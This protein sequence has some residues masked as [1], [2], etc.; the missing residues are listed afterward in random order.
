MY[1]IVKCVKRKPH[2]TIMPDDDNCKVDALKEFT[3]ELEQIILKIREIEEKV[4]S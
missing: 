3:K 4:K 2:E 1:K